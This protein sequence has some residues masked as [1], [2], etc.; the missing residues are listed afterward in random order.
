MVQ[1]RQQLGRDSDT[2]V[3]HVDVYDPCSIGDLCL[4]F[5]P[6]SCPFVGFC[7]FDHKKDKP[8]SFFQDVFPHKT[9]EPF[10][11]L[12]LLYMLLAHQC[13]GTLLSV[14]LMNVYSRL[15]LI[16]FRVSAAKRCTSSQQCPQLCSCSSNVVAMLFFQHPQQTKNFLF[17]C[18]AVITSPTFSRQQRSASELE[19][20]WNKAKS[21]LAFSRWYAGCKL[22]FDCLPGRFLC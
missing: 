8:G 17:H 19:M 12:S 2:C 21:I 20:K 11:R 10:L 18:F 3:W 9:E 14:P 7:I 15:V 6:V 5:T 1:R 4:Y 13:T 22:N 16:M